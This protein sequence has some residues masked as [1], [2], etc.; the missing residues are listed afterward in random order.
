MTAKIT[1][2]NGRPP[3]TN[4]TPA[5]LL[6]YKKKRATAKSYYYRIVRPR[7]IAIKAEKEAHLRS[8]F[9]KKEVPT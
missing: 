9:A 8:L 3:L 7:N 5:Q 1:H 2:P 6:I 4:L